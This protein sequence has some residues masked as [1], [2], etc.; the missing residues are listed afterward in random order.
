MLTLPTPSHGATTIFQ[1]RPPVGLRYLVSFNSLV[2][3]VIFFGIERRLSVSPLGSD[4]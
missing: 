4:G 1:V 3:D 2:Y